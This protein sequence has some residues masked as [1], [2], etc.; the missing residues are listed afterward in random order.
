MTIA[1]VNIDL[2]FPIFI[3][4]NFVLGS[5]T[6]LP[7]R[8]N[9]FTQ[10]ICSN[11]LE[12]IP[13]YRVALTELTRVSVTVIIEQAVFFDPTNFLEEDHHYFTIRCL[14][15]KNKGVMVTLIKMLL[16]VKLI[17][18]VLRVLTR[19]HRHKNFNRPQSIRVY[20][21]SVSDRCL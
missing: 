5:I 19:S 21:K 16:R 12:H 6:H 4:E 1:R 11:V 9:A 15:V 7:F 18:H 14:F 8:T 10:A 2:R 17:R 3:P 20:Q 13:N